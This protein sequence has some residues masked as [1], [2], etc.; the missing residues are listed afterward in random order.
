MKKLPKGAGLINAA[1]NGAYARMADGEMV[2][3]DPDGEYLFPIGRGALGPD[4]DESIGPWVVLTDGTISSHQGL[5]FH[6]TQVPFRRKR[7]AP[8][9]VE[10]DGQ[11]VLSNGTDIVM[12]KDGTTWTTLASAGRGDGSVSGMTVCGGELLVST[13]DGE[14]Y[15]Y[16]PEH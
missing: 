2:H 16:Q 13:H 5:E 1:A 9:P 3:V 6:P 7:G 15:A 11:L 14:V 4:I 12:T 8:L 10:L